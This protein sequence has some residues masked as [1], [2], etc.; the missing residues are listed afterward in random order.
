MGVGIS[1]LT[2]EG[3]AGNGVIM[4]QKT[5][6]L[7][8]D[9]IDGSEAAGTVRF[10]LDGAEYEIDLSTEHALALRDVLAEYAGAARRPRAN[11][12][13]PARSG[14]STPAGGLNAAD[15]RDWARAQDIEIKDRGRIPAEVVTRFKAATGR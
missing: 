5:Q 8:V 3:R 11:G 9:D 6:I 10:G 12:R 1:S 4:A 15:I 2:H 14:R 13:R 7:L